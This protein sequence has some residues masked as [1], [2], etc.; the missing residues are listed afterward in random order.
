M[1][2][3]TIPLKYRE[4]RIPT[5]IILVASSSRYGDYFAGGVGST[6]WL[7]DLKLIYDESE[8]KE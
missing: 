6:M 3:F 2:E 1:V 7:D 8:L 4:G 5:D